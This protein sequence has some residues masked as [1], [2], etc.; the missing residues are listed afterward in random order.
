MPRKCRKCD[1]LIRDDEAAAPGWG[2]EEICASCQFADLRAHVRMHETASCL[3]GLDS[4]K[5][6]E[7]YRNDPIANRVVE[8]IVQERIPEELAYFREKLTAAEEQIKIMVQK[9]ADKHLDGYRE[10]GQEL[11]KAKNRMGE[12]ECELMNMADDNVLMEKRAEKAEARVTALEEAGKMLYE[13]VD[14]FRQGAPE[15]IDAWLK[16]IAAT[17][18]AE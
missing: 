7:L 2:P 4:E 15:A 14:Y 11:A 13:T 17:K 1:R 16:A 12:M 5:L 10:M 3:Q 18:E 9:A 6:I 8:T